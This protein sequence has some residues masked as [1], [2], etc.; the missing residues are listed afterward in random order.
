ML[1]QDDSLKLSFSN[2]FLT[3]A[4]LKKMRSENPIDAGNMTSIFSS[5]GI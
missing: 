1:N 5:W 2:M 3:F 4:G